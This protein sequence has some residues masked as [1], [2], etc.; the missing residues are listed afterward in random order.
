MI[1]EIIAKIAKA[2]AE[3]EEDIYR[4]IEDKQVEMSGLISEEGAAY[5]VAKEL[6]VELRRE[7]EK[8][9][10]ESVAAGMQ[11]ADVTGKITRIFP[12]R[13]FKT[14]KAEGRVANIIIADKTGS[15]RVSLWNEEIEK[16]NSLSV[17]DVIRVR[18][19]VRDNNGQPEMRMGRKGNIIKL[20]DA[21]GFDTIVYERKAER[22]SV[23][24]LREGFYRSI[25]A[26]ILQIFD[27]NLFFEIC[28]E[29]RKRLKE[30]ETAFTCAEHGEVIPNYGM[31]VSGIIDDSTGNIRAVFFT[32][33]AEKIIGMSVADAKKLF[34][35]KKKTESILS[36]IPLGKE[37]VFE[38]SVR[39]NA[40]FDRLE[41]VVND[42][43][44]VDIKK[45]IEMMV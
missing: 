42:V 29:C 36:Q 17:G 27:T 12:V 37:F 5:L 3:T 4:M 44:A 18:G 32:E 25:R 30:T 22:S 19:F 9:N 35:R 31:I 34:D 41:F 23:S 16:L 40:F 14:E 43:K 39:R 15:I 13:E 21:E 20:H 33:A 7:V 45:E 6:G 1:D 24:E 10:I 38:G 8:L 11:N 26:P 28:P 2:T